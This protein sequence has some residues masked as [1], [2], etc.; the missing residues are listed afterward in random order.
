MKLTDAHYEQFTPR[1]RV[2][3]FWDAMGRKDLPEADKL[4]GTCPEKTYR[5]QD[6]AYIEGVRAIHYCCMHALL[7]MEQAAGGAMAALGI[8]AATADSKARDKRK[9]FS[10][11]AE[12]YRVASGRL[13]GYWDAWREFCAEVKVD[14]EAVMRASW[15]SVPQSIVD[16]LLPELS[17]LVEADAEA[18]AQA[19]GLFRGRWETYQRRTDSN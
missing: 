2:A 12:A 11:A 5:M 17:E 6:V 7:L 4:I 1:E 18:K 9:L 19:L 3:L 10:G 14:P 15:G 16:P 8:L 13:F